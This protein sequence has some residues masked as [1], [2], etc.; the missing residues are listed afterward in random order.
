MSDPNTPLHGRPSDAEP[1]RY[2]ERVETPPQYG[3]RVDAPPQY[4]E[5]V[6]APPQ[7]GE[8]V[9]QPIAPS[10]S[11]PAQAPAYVPV[12]P[13]QPYQGTTPTPGQPY[14]PAGV[15]G[16]PYGA[17]LPPGYQPQPPQRTN[18][19]AIVAL[20]ISIVA[21][22]QVGLV[23][24]IFALVQ[25]KKTHERGRGLAIAAVVIGAIS[26]V[27]LIAVLIYLNA[28]GITLDDFL[29]QLTTGDTST[30]TGGTPA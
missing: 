12:V 15:P 8:R 14:G 3:E 22:A 27:V 20:V 4:G 6:D 16:Q 19:L 24:G 10:P 11:Q 18:T 21:Q 17:P 30:V 25:I 28:N 1:P 7:Y 9:A 5:R 13:G 23:L 29:N 26:T 2:G